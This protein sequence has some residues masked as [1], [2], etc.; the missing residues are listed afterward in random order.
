MSNR[1]REE[2]ALYYLYLMSDG[3]S[4]PEHKKLFDEICQKLGFSSNDQQKIIAVC[5]ASSKSS[6]PYEVIEGNRLAE[7]ATDGDYSSELRAHII[8]N[9]VNLGYP[10]LLVSANKKKVI[11]HLLSKWEIDPEIYT[12]MLDIA[13]TVEALRKQ[14]NWAEKT[15][16]PGGQKEAKLKS[17]GENIERIL[18]DVEITINELAAFE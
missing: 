4:L 7:A 8:W 11:D 12:E 3:R 17:L 6:S 15:L 18:S 10:D 9:L 13:D 14:M 5:K 2:V 1:K 16:P